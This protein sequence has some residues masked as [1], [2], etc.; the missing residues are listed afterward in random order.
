METYIRHKRTG[1]RYLFVKEFIY[2]RT[3]R[4]YSNG[5]LTVE[6]LPD[7]RNGE[8]YYEYY[9]LNPKTGKP[10]QSRKASLAGLFEKEGGA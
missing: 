8:L 4:S 10:W 7:I 1:K 5:V 2:Q 6:N 9:N 3:I